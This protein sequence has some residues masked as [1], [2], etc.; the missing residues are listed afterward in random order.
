MSV[1]QEGRTR[2]F[3]AGT[4]LSSSQYCFVKLDST[5]NQVVLATAGT[6]KIIGVLQNAPVSGDVATVGL[7]AGSG[8]YKVRASTSIALNA[9]VTATTAGK[10]V[11]TTTA[12]HVVA[13]IALQAATA[14]NDYI[15]VMPTNFH[16]KA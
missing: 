14:E 8:T 2:T 6:D 12:G 16:H 3:K 15:E 10:A 1:M 7:L 4:D 9:Y 13:G 5:Q 11:T